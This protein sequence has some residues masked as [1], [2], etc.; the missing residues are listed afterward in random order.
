MTTNTTAAPSLGLAPHD[1]HAVTAND[2]RRF[3]Y[4]WFTLFEHR[5]PAERLAAH[6]TASQPL[7]LTFPGAE[8]L[9]DIQQFTDW[10][11]QLLA[12]TTWNFHELSG[13]TVELA[14]AASYDVSID[15][16]WQ[17][18]VTED[19]AWPTNLP[20]RRFHFDVR[21]RWQVAV[22]PGSAQDDPFY[23]V[24]LVAEPL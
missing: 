23:I 20:E 22:H 9:R 24:N 8:P 16:G 4:T 11:K 15:I 21:Q 6:L 5:A 10:Y 18:A 7:S 13:I 3:V 17:G 19:S 2:V 1:V 12:N 14:E